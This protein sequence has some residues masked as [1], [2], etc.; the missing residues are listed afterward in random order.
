MARTYRAALLGCGNRGAHASRAYRHHPRTDVV[1]LCDLDR[2][3]LDA[4]GGEL[5]VADRFDDVEAMLAAV[6]GCSLPNPSVLLRGQLCLGP[7]QFC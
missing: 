4:L 3:R 7:S 2:S 1:G 5:G 6:D